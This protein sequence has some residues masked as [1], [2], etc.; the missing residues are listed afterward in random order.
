M[1]KTSIYLVLVLAFCLASSVNATN[2]IWVSDFFDDNGDGAPDDQ[3]WVELLEAQGYTVDY[4]SHMGASGV[5]L[6][7]GYWSALDDDKIA[8]LNAADLII[9]SR[10]SNSGDYANGDESTQWNSVTTPIILQAMHIV[11][12][13]RWQWLDTT[14]LRNLPG[15]VADILAADHPIFDGVVPSAQVLDGTVELTTFPEITGVGVGNGT[16]IA[17]V[18]VPDADVAWIVEWEAGVEFYDGSGQIAGG[19]RMIFPAGTQESGGVIGR[20]EYNLTPE[21]EMIF[22]NAVNYMLGISELEPVDPGTDGLIAYYPLENDVSDNSGNGNDGIVEG[23]PT[24]IEGPAS[25]GMAI[26]FDGDDHV[27]TGNTEDLAEWT[28]AC[29]AKSPSAPSGDPSSASGPVH[30]DRNY[31][32]N[33]NH[34]SDVPRGSVDVRSAGGWHAASFGTLKA[35]TW[36]HLAGTYDG[37]EL[38][39]YKDGVLITTNDAPSGPP[40]AE[41]GTL[42]L[43]KHATAEQYFTGTVDEAVIYNRAL[44][45][46]EIRYLAG[47]RAM[48]DPGTDALVAAYAFESDVL[49][50]SGNG[51][52]ATINGDPMFVEVVDGMALEFDGGGDFLDCGANPI[53]ALTDAVSIS[54]W[55]KVAVQGADHKVGGNQDSAN[56]GYK[57]SVYNDKIE[58]EI[59][60]ASNASVL[61]RS[62]EGGTEILVDVWYH[63]VGVYSLEDGYIRTY[64]DGELDRELLTTRALGASPGPLMIGCE[65]FNT[66]L[67]NFNGVMDEI[68]VYNKALS[69]A[70][71]RYL[72]NN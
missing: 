19:L 18:P 55:I 27:D 54:A 44:S 34:Q 60:T 71:A 20:G 16:L 45:D 49:D 22:L 7:Y 11:R 67:Y 10:N 56:G 47:F 23:D 38:K 9:V 3:A 2:I 30:R 32:F 31:Q 63:V 33:W 25:Y 5:S 53:L 26:E 24:Y 28:I 14:T 1:C 61:N 36:Y 41:A 64:V 68:R 58:F 62:V 43:G 40:L 4:T 72:A 35:D 8:A 12:S 29:W 65:P 15:F 37:E 48:E 52:D 51:N 21:G 59:R 69:D 50:S 46:G 66:G 39:A 42:K 13:N 6:G 17:K 57:M 70:E